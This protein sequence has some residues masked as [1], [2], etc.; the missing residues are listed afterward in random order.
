M[1]FDWTRFCNQYGV[2]FAQG[3]ANTSRNNITVHCPFCGPADPSMHMSVSLVGKGWRC[4]RHPGHRGKNPTR[5]VQALLRCDWE[6]AAKITGQAIYVPS[7]FM[8][9]VRGAISPQA[10]EVRR[11]LKEPKEF[12]R[13]EGLPSSRPFVSYLRSRG[14]TDDDIAVMSSRYSM[15]YCTQGAYRHRIMFMVRFMGDLVAWTGRS[16]ARDAELRY[17]ALSIDPERAQREGYEPALGAI[18]HYLLWWDRLQ[19]VDADTLIL[20]EGPF[21]ALKVDVLGNRHGVAATCFFTSAPT[22]AQMAL[23]HEICPQFRRKV[24]L[25]DRGTLALSMRVVSSLSS[26]GVVSRELGQGLKDPGEFTPSTFE[27]F[28]LELPRVRN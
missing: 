28:L 24:M 6:R 8:D 27:K 3:G 18:S 10:I 15:R 4:W 5:L 2:A 12:K 22:D 1:A 16:I 9:R 14:F 21:D 26:L 25:L 13:F 17:R 19:R 7:D 23:L 20:C 11:P